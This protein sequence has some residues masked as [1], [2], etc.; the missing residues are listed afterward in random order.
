MTKN[1]LLRWALPL[2][3]VAVLAVLVCMRVFAPARVVHINFPTAATTGTLYPLGAAFSSLWNEK[4]PGV[5][6]TAQASGG[7]VD[8]LNFLREG[9]AQVSMA[10]TS[11]AWQSA[12]GTATFEGKPDAKLRMLA[13]LY[14]NP[15]QVVAAEGSGITSLADIAGKRFAPGAPGSTTV[16]E[17]QAHLTRAGVAY[18]DGFSAQFVGFNEAID[19]MRNRQLD[20]AWIMAGLPT[21]AVS[22]ICATAGGHLVPVDDAVLDALQAEYPWYVRFIIPAGTYAGQEE[23]V[24]TSAVRMVLMASADLDEEIAYQLTKTLWENMTSLQAGFAALN[25][26]E[27]AKAATDIAGLPLHDGA[28]RYYRE[29]GVL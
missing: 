9:E 5:Q 20:G 19:L 14:Y 24:P 4:V 15:N 7:G 16:G 26:C 17:T 8:N 21:A 22:E 2:V 13:G 6:V 3:L 11:V 12:H 27:A 10:V 25:G 23:D 29:I 1:K 28:A 18:P